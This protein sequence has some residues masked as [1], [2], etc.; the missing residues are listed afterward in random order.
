MANPGHHD[1]RLRTAGRTALGARATTT[2]G[3]DMTLDAPDRH[4]GSVSSRPDDAPP[5]TVRAGDLV[6]QGEEFSRQSRR[7]RRRLGTLVVLTALVAG[8]ASGGAVAFLTRGRPATVTSAGASPA[9]TP[10]AALGSAPPTTQAGGAPPAA[11]SSIVKMVN[12]SVAAIDVVAAT[13]DE[14]GLPVTEKSS[15]SAFVVAANGLLATN[16]HVVADERSMSVT[17]SDGK[18][19]VATLVGKDTAED[20]AVVHIDRTDL[21]PLEL[22]TSFDVVVGDLAIAAGNALALDGSPSV[23]IGIVSGL[24]RTITPAAGTTMS[25]LIQTDAAISS[26]NSGGPLFSVT[27]VVIGVNTASA[28]STTTTTAQNIGFAIPITRAAPV[29]ARLIATPS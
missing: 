6:L 14:F 2:W 20:L 4:D 26:G 15:G 29:I 13:T 5:V 21:V 17:F 23:T 7:Q 18:T 28:L 3:E 11:L 27:G 24:D 8:G 12:T 16:A 25:H 9:A 19:Y 1:E 22:G 10:S